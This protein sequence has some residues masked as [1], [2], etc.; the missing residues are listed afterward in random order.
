MRIEF[1]EAV[2]PGQPSLAAR[3]DQPEWGLFVPTVWRMVADPAGTHAYPIHPRPLEHNPSL[4]EWWG[5]C[6]HLLAYGLG[7]RRID[8]GLRRWT[9]QGRPID[10]ER[11]AVVSG[12]WG[13]QLDDLVDWLSRAGGGQLA[14]MIASRLG[15]DW[16]ADTEPTSD[17][18]PAPPIRDG[19]DFGGGTDPLHLLVHAFTGVGE[20]TDSAE[21]P[22]WELHRGADGHASLLIDRYSGWYGVLH[23]VGADLPH[24]MGDRSWRVD[25]VVK[26]LG[27][28]GTYRRSRL[29]GRWFS[30]RHRVHE[31]G[32]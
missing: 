21:R 14:E 29:T 25:V 19:S 22:T 28:L 20:L 31:L 30:G 4:T 17:S 18:Q 5:P 8:V 32:A 13:A 1:S 26:P 23:E 24:L 2:D 6:L 10:D 9:E 3:G 7:W 27:W 11:L 16:P 12:I 15:V